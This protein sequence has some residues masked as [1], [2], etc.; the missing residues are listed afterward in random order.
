MPNPFVVGPPVRGA[1]LC[2]RD[3]EVQRIASVLREGGSVAV[4]GVA[5]CGLT[6]LALAVAGRVGGTER[7]AVRV[8]TSEAEDAGAADGLLRRAMEGIEGHAEGSGGPF[9]LLL[10]GLR[11]EAAVEAGRHLLRRTA[12]RRAGTLLLGAPRLV[13]DLAAELG[14]SGGSGDTGGGGGGSGRHA[15]TIELSSPPAA[16]WLPYVLERFL[17]TDRWIGNR[18]VEA[19]LETTGGVP[20]PTQAVLRALW[21]AT[22]TE[23]GLPDGAVERALALAVDRE[24]AGFRRLMDG[25]TVNQRRVLRGLARLPDVPPFSGR[26]V[27]EQGLASPSSV[28]RALQAL[29]ELGLAVRDDEDR[30]R[31][32]DPLLERWLRRQEAAAV[33]VKR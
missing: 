33:D 2:G 17:E 7:P 24:T 22:G 20:R 6:S 10:D 11:R 31:P 4:C 28:Q 12:G 25:L 16:A 5:G 26:F 1:D 15:G 18:H 19:V 32:A 9:H 8:E 27:S 14:P 23:R 3:V 21:D 30:P 29:E 13:P